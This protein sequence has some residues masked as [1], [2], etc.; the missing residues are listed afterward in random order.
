MLY[1]CT[2]CKTATVEPE[3]QA[4]LN[5]SWFVFP[6]ATYKLILETQ[7][8]FPMETVSQYILG[9]DISA[10]GNHGAKSTISI[11]PDHYV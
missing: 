2:G 7:M 5:S 9:Q 1:L 8:Y 6:K 10:Y 11:T 3:F 4:G